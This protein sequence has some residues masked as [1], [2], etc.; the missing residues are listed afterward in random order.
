M[1]EVR[2]KPQILDAF[3]YFLRRQWWR[4]SPNGTLSTCSYSIK[5]DIFL[6]NGLYSL[7]ILHCFENTEKNHC[8]VFNFYISQYS[9]LLVA[10]CVGEKRE[11][12]VRAFWSYAS[13]CHVF[14][15][16][17]GITWPASFSSLLTASTCTF[18]VFHQSIEG[19]FRKIH[20]EMKFK[21]LSLFWCRNSFENHA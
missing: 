18:S 4:N 9:I 2:E 15:T 5:E 7:A 8:G 10:L 11:V 6:T 17:A 1:W 16:W 12:A 19:N 3:A 21:Y 20:G 13:S 14:F